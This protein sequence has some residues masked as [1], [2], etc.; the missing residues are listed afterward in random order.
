M[1]RT[2][3]MNAHNKM[4]SP[5]IK[6]KPW[7][8]AVLAMIAVVVVV[9]LAVRLISQAPKKPPVL[10]GN[11]SQAQL[12]SL[13]ATVKP[14]GEMQFLTV[15]LNGI[16]RVVSELSWV[17]SVSV[18][19]DWQNAA[20]ITV[21]PRQAVANFGSQYLL[22]AGGQV[23]VPA[24][25][26]ELMN[27]SLVNLYSRHLEDAE[28]M[29]QQ[30]R[31][32][33][34]WFADFGLVAQDV[35]LTA[36]HTWLIRFNNGLRV[37]VDRENTEQK[38]YSLATLLKRDLAADLPKIQAVD[39]RYKNGFAITWRETSQSATPVKSPS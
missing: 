30:T 28:Q 21:V 10:A 6:V 33:N 19:R 4:T 1:I 11:L 26:H 27:K 17:E 20:V 18:R 37:V 13:Q 8:K 2:S 22:D 32:V 38:L 25:E 34:E 29:M 15:D 31:R 9:F 39:L 5:S 12:S 14:L 36:R 24:D 3:M 35:T 16:H 23:F 7:Q